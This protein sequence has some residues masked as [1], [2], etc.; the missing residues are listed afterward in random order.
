M[1]GLSLAALGQLDPV[2]A[3]EV[4]RRSSVWEIGSRLAGLDPATQREVVSRAV[5]WGVAEGA[6]SWLR[7]RAAGMSHLGQD[8]LS[9]AVQFAVERALKPMMPMLGQRLMEVAEPAA[10]RAAEVVGPVV[11]DKL[12]EYGPRLAIIA[13]VVAAIL[14][15][16]GMAALGWYVARKVA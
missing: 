2:T 13:G 3:Q 6:D 16:L 10:K 4:A 7:A 14:G 12:K 9:T 8:A 11:E 15:L 1:N 5:H